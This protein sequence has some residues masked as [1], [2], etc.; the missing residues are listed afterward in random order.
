MHVLVSTAVL[1][2]TLF[3]GGCA[4]RSGA[5]RPDAALRRELLAMCEVDQK[6][7]QSFGSH[8]SADENAA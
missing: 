5:T 1:L 2:T 3:V 4:S 7:R 6:V 8:M